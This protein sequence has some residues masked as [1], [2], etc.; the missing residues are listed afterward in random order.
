MRGPPWRHCGPRWRITRR[1]WSVRVRAGGSGSVSGRPMW[2]TTF[3]TPPCRRRPLRG[4]ATLSGPGSWE[5][6]RFVRHAPCPTVGP[7]VTIDPRAR[8]G[9]RRCEVAPGVPPREWSIDRDGFIAMSGGPGDGG[10]ARQARRA[11]AE[12][13]AAGVGQ[14]RGQVDRRCRST[15][16]RDAATVSRGRRDDGGRCR[17]QLERLKARTGDRRIR[18]SG[19]DP[20]RDEMIRAE[21]VRGNV[22][23]RCAAVDASIPCDGPPAYPGAGSAAQRGSIARRGATCSSVC[24]TR[25][26]RPSRVPRFTGRSVGGRATCGSRRG[27]RA[28]GG[29]GGRGG[30]MAAAGVHCLLPGSACGRTLP[31]GGRASRRD[32]PEGGGGRR[33]PYM[34]PPRCHR[35]TRRHGDP[36]LPGERPGPQGGSAADPGAQRAPDQREL[37]RALITRSARTWRGKNGPAPGRPSAMGPCRIGRSRRGAVRPGRDHLPAGD[38]SP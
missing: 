15:D 37:R 30:G 34:T 10:K 9:D 12:A 4:P 32:V 31:G 20:P 2:G 6:R 36:A 23:A 25:S 29:R 24:E 27:A 22:Q 26:G 3:A 1:W 14:G 7:I 28:A 21:A 35:R 38:P 5:K 11:C 8:P 18:R 19:S 33:L 13:A 16:R 17:D